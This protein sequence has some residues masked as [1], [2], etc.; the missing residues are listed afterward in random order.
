[1]KRIFERIVVSDVPPTSDAIWIDT[2]SET[3]KMKMSLDGQQWI[4]IDNSNKE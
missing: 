3:P 2:S 1:M 4:T